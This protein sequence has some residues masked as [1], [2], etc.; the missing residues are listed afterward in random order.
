MRPPSFFC[1][2]S[3]CSSSAGVS[4]GPA[5]PAGAPAARATLPPAASLAS[6]SSSPRR[7]VATTRLLGPRRGRRRRGR[8]GRRRRG[9][10]RRRRRRLAVRARRGGRG[11]VS[12]VI[13]VRGR[14]SRLRQQRRLE[15]PRLVHRLHVA[16]LL[17]LVLLRLD[18]LRRAVDL[19]EHAALA[20]VVGDGVELMAILAPE[21]L[22]EL[23]PLL[24][25]LL[26]HAPKI[27]LVIH[28]V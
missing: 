2:S 13:R 5:S 23:A 1:A 22:D 15:R 9:R 28:D 12:L 8:W 17:D 11:R 7:F 27:A 24:H 16:D 18:L 25:L 19:L 3:A 14:G 21:A 10:R 6:M 4:G 26:E 20:A